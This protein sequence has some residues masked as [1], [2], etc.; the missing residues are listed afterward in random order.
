MTA[1]VR[2][3][4]ADILRDQAYGLMCS[5]PEYADPPQFFTLL[6]GA[7]MLDYVDA[8]ESVELADECADERDALRLVGVELEGDKMELND[9]NKQLKLANKKLT[10]EIETL[11]R[12]LGDLI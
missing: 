12:R 8:R 11:K 6:D 2:T 10:E 9:A 4:C 1:S 5:P 3:V 7:E